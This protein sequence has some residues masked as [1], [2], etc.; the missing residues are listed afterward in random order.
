[1]SKVFD[2]IDTIKV[3]KLASDLPETITATVL[4][5]SKTE[6]KGAYAGAPV[7]KLEL[8]TTD[9]ITFSSQYRIP[10][11]W[12]G[13]GQMDKLIECLDKLKVPLHQIIGKTF[14]W[15]RIDLEGSVKGN[16]RFYPMRL[17]KETKAK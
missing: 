6:K 10:K 7:L 4:A 12:T 3:Q 9:G 8:Q 13:K 14:E 5:A 1:M 15:K 17:I 11:T 16:P 2:E